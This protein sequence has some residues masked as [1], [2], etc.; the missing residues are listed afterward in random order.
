MFDINV[1]QKPMNYS[2]GKIK[3]LRND[4]SA[5][6]HWTWR[7]R[8]NVSGMLMHL[9]KISCN[10][11]FVEN[12]RK[13]NTLLPSKHRNKIF[14]HTLRVAVRF[15]ELEKMNHEGPHVSFAQFVPVQP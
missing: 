4:M 2:K 10:L 14:M 1:F 15:L 7:I 3:N 13:G 6:I 5:L 11:P 8:F 12:C 9:R